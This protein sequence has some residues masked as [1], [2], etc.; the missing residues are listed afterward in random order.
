MPTFKHAQTQC[1]L[2]GNSRSIWTPFLTHVQSI[3]IDSGSTRR[4]QLPSDPFDSYVEKSILTC[5]QSL[6]GFSHRF[7]AAV[8]FSHDR[9]FL[10]DPNGTV[11][12]EGWQRI[13]FQKLGELCGFAV[14]IPGTGLQATYEQGPWFSYRAVIVFDTEIPET[15][16]TES[17]KLRLEH[18]LHDQIPKDRLGLWQHQVNQLISS[19]SSDNNNWSKWLD[20][21][22]DIGKALGRHDQKF[23][24][25]QCKYHYTKDKVHLLS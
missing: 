18:W 17:N 11:L 1:L 24:D 14:S 3:C 15:L 10:L 5:L 22:V 7:S 19:Q 13:P 12:D 8:H 16:S 23:C 25:Q 9:F 21:R 20:L 2:I 4:H 6:D